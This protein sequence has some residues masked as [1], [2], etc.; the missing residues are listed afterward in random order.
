MLQVIKIIYINKRNSCNSR[1]ER[2]QIIF[3][4]LKYRKQLS[5]GTKIGRNNI[6]SRKRF[7]V[8]FYR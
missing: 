2:C 4:R 8:G 7:F 3:R 1:N 6:N 5:C